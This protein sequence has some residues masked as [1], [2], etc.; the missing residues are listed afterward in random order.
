MT[1]RT[2]FRLPIIPCSIALL[3]L[4][5]MTTTS[6][7]QPA[8]TSF[9]AQ[10]TKLIPSAR[11]SF[12]ERTLPNTDDPA[13]VYYPKLP[14]RLRGSYGNFPVVIM[15]QGARV[16]RKYY[17]Q[18]ARELARY[19]FVVIVPDHT[20]SV[21]AEVG[22]TE[23]IVITDSLEL[24]EGETSN[25]DSPLY[26]VVDTTT[27]ALSGHSFGTAAALF[28][29]GGLCTFPFCDPRVGFE[30]PSAVKAAAVL[31]GNTRA[32]DIDSTGIPV[33]IIVGDIDTGRDD[34]ERTYGILEPPRAFIEI[35]DANHYGLNDTDQPPEAAVREDEAKQTTPQSIS[36]ARFGQWAGIFLRAHLY[37]DQRAWRRIYVSGGNANVTISS[38]PD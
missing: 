12:V 25:P 17:S 9:E 31:A 3:C 27:A 1:D 15:M 23:F 38:Q 7:A 37:G 24:L 4:L 6:F 10:P 30:L 14:P 5:G 33:A 20:S 19:G 13:T 22:F 35:R 11:I 29:V 36:A 18:Y 34:G 32:L 21:L 2:L 28:A 8:P 26:G 16:L